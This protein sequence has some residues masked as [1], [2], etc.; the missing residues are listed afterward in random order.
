[1]ASIKLHIFRTGMGDKGLSNVDYRGKGELGAGEKDQHRTVVEKDPADETEIAAALISGP[2]INQSL[3]ALNDLVPNYA[4]E[5]AGVLG[6]E[7]EGPIGLRLGVW[8]K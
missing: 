8:D 3:V 6:L 7:G 1:M 2:R 4:D 5:L